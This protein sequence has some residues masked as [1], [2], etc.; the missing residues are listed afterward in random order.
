MPK[1]TAAANPAALPADPHNG[2]LVQFV[3]PAS[4][5]QHYGLVVSGD[6]LAPKVKHGDV[7]VVDTTRECN[8]GDLVVIYF[9]PECVKPGQ[10]L[11]MIKRLVTGMPPFVRVPHQDHPDS[12]V[13]AGIMLQMDNP[14]RALFVQCA[15]L[16]AVHRCVGVQ[17][18]AGDM[19]A[20]RPRAAKKASRRREA[21]NA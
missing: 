2:A 7:V 13:R 14:A 12:E 17:P 11:R 19:P 16:L 5:P 3:D 20:P 1:P 8:A 21:A 9:R 4:L 18:G 6:C 15:E 10:P